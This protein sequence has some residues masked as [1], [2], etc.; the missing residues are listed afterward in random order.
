MKL[1]KLLKN[2]M[3]LLGGVAIIFLLL[4]GL[5]LFIF[6]GSVFLGSFGT[7]SSTVKTASYYAP[8]LEGVSSVPYKGINNEIKKSELIVKEASFDIKSKDSESD[9]L[10]IENEVKRLN[11]YVENKDIEETSTYKKIYLLVRVPFDRFEDLINYLQNFKITKS[12]VKNYRINIYL[13]VKE[14]DII[15]QGIEDYN[16]I[17]QKILAKEEY[18]ADDLRLLEQVLNSQRKLSK[19]LSLIT[20]NL[21][22]E[23]MK[24]QYPKVSINIYEEK[25]INL[26]DK[27]FVKDIWLSIKE[28]INNIYKGIK[29][30]IFGSIKAIVDWTVGITHL[31]IATIYV[32]FYFVILIS[33]LMIGFR[34]I[35]KIW[36]LISRFI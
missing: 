11:G 7:F 1:E 8:K 9:A 27:D 12:N 16:L 15:L 10:K 36:D 2:K 5:I 4:A 22:L 6:L 24:S 30:I 20:Y 28:L 32:I 17:K 18:T 33:L 35:L 34:I 13:K 31:I 19:D 26:F 21:Y 14:E 3:Y 25:P 23:Q 29:E